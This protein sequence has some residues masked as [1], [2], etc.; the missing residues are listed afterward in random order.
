MTPAAD[1]TTL[2]NGIRIVTLRMPHFRSVSMGVWV[3]A[4]ARD[5]TPDESGLSHLIEHMIFKG[6]RRRS[7]FRI[8]K[9][10]D[11]IGGYTNAFT[12]METTC[13]HAKVLDNHLGA[14]V[15]I[16]SDIFL[17]SLFD[18]SELN[19]EKPIILQE[20]SMMEDS[21]DDYIHQ[22]AGTAFWG[23]HA[24]GR[25]ILG[26]PENIERFSA[27]I[28][29]KFF[30]RLYQPDR[31]IIAA[32]GNLS[33]QQIVD[34]VGMEFE[35]IEPGTGFPERI[36]PKT[37]TGIYLH[38]RELEQSHICLST[39]GLS[40]HDPRRFAGSLLN[41]IV[42]GNMSSRLFQEIREKRSLAYTVYSFVSAY[43][44]A[45]MF[46]AYAAVEPGN[47]FETVRFMQDELIRFL[48]TT[49]T[50]SELTDAK[51]FTKGSLLLAAESTDN[52]MVRLAQNEMHLERYVPLSEIIA[53]IESVTPE[54]ILALAR[55]LFADRSMALTVLGPSPD[56]SGFQEA[57]FR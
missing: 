12:S 34:L 39:P 42:G 44:D 22:L 14:M 50:E 31:I 13:Y 54:D 49:V 3:D 17:N 16:L 35:K 46:G 36:Q 37:Q 26:P 27:D 32:S 38:H 51:E 55:E 24:L 7:A 2:K 23:D 57:L 9:E 40:I 6:T 20:I 43:V 21:P 56:Q 5:E 53:E 47:S 8:A 19:R 25:S 11:A 18:A 33:H 30:S 15:D 10:F 45:G 1:K 52:Q 29:K 41:T 28:L 48:D 4:G